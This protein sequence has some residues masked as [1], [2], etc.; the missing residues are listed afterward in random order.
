MSTPPPD[1]LGDRSAERDA[2]PADRPEA[3]RAA[4]PGSA[5]ADRPEETR[6]AQPGSASADR[7][8]ATRAAQPG[9]A[10]GDRPAQPGTTFADWLALREPADAAARSVELVERL[11]LRPPLVVHDLGSG[12]GSMVRWLA[13]RLPGPQHWVLHDRYAALLARAA[14]TMPPGITVE[15]RPGDLTELRSADLAGASLVTASALLDMLT[16]E[17]VDAVVAACAGRPTLLTLSVIG[18]VA[19]SPDDPLDPEVAAAFD[20]HQRRTVEG[21]RLLGPDAADAAAAAFRRRGIPVEVRSTPWRLGPERAALAAEWF[22]GWVAAAREQRPDLDTGAYQARRSAEIRAGRV[23]ITVGHRDLFAAGN[24]LNPGSRSP[25][26]RSSEG[27]SRGD[28]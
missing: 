23:R 14:A 12:T 24:S 13:P 2:A 9:S 16:A 15:T 17:E 7:P 6:A 19:F 28:R 4:Q 3:T 8:E 20:D 27:R 10:L 5:F 21:R 11:T 22:A 26:V 25:V 1:A 18:S